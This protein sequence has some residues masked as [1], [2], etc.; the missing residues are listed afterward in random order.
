M[1]L[2]P[3]SAITAILWTVQRTEQVR[4]ER[5]PRRQELIWCDPAMSLCLCTYA[6][7]RDQDRIMYMR[8]RNVTRATNNPKATSK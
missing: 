7:N 5:M 2:E 4:Y 8:V 6:G 1:A 3:P